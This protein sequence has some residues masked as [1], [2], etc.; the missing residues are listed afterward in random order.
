L[1]TRFVWDGDALIGEL[2]LEAKGDGEPVCTR[3]REWVY[4]P[5]SFEPLTMVEADGLT[6][7]ADATGANAANER[8][9]YYANDPNGCPTRLLDED[10]RER[11][12]T[13][14]KDVLQCG[15]I[16]YFRLAMALFFIFDHYNR[17]ALQRLGK[18]CKMESN[19]IKRAI[20]RLS[21]FL[22]K[23]KDGFDKSRKANNVPKSVSA[24]T[25]TR[26]WS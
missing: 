13:A 14:S 5:G 16:G 6:G 11:R 21:D 9:Y 26:F 10:G 7:E 18:L 2:R 20:G 22:N 12:K 24:E 4:Y 1:T 19:C 23:T 17:T 8:V 25:I 15:F 3:V